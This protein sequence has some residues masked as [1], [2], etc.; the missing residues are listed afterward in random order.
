MITLTEKTDMELYG[1]RLNEFDTYVDVISYLRNFAKYVKFVLDKNNLTTD[2]RVFEDIITS[3]KGNVLFVPEV[4]KVEFTIN[5]YDFINQSIV[6]SRLNL[7]RSIRPTKVITKYINDLDNEKFDNE[8]FKWLRAAQ[9]KKYK[10][11]SKHLLETNDVFSVTIKDDDTRGDLSYDTF[12]KL[13]SEAIS[14]QYH[15][16][17]NFENIAV[18]AIGY[19]QFADE[20]KKKP[21]YRF[22]DGGLDRPYIKSLVGQLEELV[23][24]QD[25]EFNTH[26]VVKEYSKVVKELTKLSS[27]HTSAFDEIASEFNIAML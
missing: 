26:S 6:M 7:T 20:L 24:L 23:G 1:D 2:S 5:N 4:N 12:L 3:V 19:E 11:L 9:L 8:L 21:V 25:A 22:D 10:A 16:R 13:N 17:F 14:Y 18:L 15:G 27:N